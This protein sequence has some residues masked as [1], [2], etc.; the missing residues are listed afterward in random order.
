MKSWVLPKEEMEATTNV[1]H[2]YSAKEPNNFEP[3][4]A[5]SPT[6]SPTLSIIKMK[7]RK[8]R[9]RRE[10]E[11]GRERKRER[12]RESKIVILN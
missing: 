4:L 2:D 5:K 10:R 9:E 1:A 12:E 3:M 8:D 6:L 11:R 7:E